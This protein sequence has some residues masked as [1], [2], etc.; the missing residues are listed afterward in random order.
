MGRGAAAWGRARPT[1]SLGGPRR[2]TPCWRCRD[3]RGEGA[4]P[5]DPAPLTAEARPSSQLA[6]S[7]LE[8]V[9]GLIGA[10][11]G[12]AVILIIP[13]VLWAKLGAGEEKS[14]RRVGPAVLLVSVGLF[15]MVGGVA[16]EIIQIINP[17]SDSPSPPSAVPPPPLI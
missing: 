14:L 7:S 1:A 12:S 3:G 10:L 16:A 5:S 17:D 11:C 15:V 9:F 13:G 2:R 8:I 4:Q 6:G